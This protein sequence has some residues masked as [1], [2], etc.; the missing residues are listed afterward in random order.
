MHIGAWKSARRPRKI[1]AV[2]AFVD[3]QDFLWIIKH[4]S[5]SV[6]PEP[7]SVLVQDRRGGDVMKMNKLKRNA[8]RLVPVLSLVALVVTAGAGVKWA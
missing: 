7:P 6:P 2:G 1:A 5:S 8:A 3:S 4:L